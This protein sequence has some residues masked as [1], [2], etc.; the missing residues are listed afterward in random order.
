MPKVTLS[1]RMNWRAAQATGDSI[2]EGRREEG[3]FNC[4]RFDTGLRSRDY[5]DPQHFFIKKQIVTKEGGNHLI[6]EELTEKK[7][8]RAK[9]VGTH[10]AYKG[11]AV[12]GEQTMGNRGIFG[13]P[14]DAPAAL[15]D[16]PSSLFCTH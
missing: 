7:T 1:Y 13:V 3:R 9:Q 15:Y 11:E 2:S 10:M 14:E 16:L 4:S 5:G 12:L 8:W 6:K